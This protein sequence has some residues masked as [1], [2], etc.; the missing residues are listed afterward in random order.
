MKIKK[1]PLNFAAPSFAEDPPSMGSPDDIFSLGMPPVPGDFGKPASTTVPRSV[2]PHTPPLAPVRVSTSRQRGGTGIYL[3]A[4]VAS[5]LWLGGVGA[6]TLGYQRHAG[7]FEDEHFTLLILAL[8]AL[9]PVGLMWISAFALRQGARLTDEIARLQHM[10][11]QMLAPTALAVAETGSAVA[12]IRQEVETASET[13]TH[14]RLELLRVRDTLAE[15]SA[16]LLEMSTRS[17]GDAV[18]LVESLGRERSAFGDLSGQLDAR[19]GDIGEAITRH[20]RMVAEASDLAQVQIQE[21]EAALAARAADLAAAAGEATE[22]ARMAGDDLARQAARLEQAG[23]TVGEQVQLVEEGLGQ[24]RAGLVT[25]AHSMRTEHEDLAVQFESQRAQL[26]ETLRASEQGALQVS[27][28]AQRGAEALREM[29]SGAA[30]QLRDMGEQAQAERDLMGGAALQ[31]LGAFSEAAAFERRALEEETR[32]AL[33]ELAAAAESAHLAAET[34][35]AAARAKVD[36]LS[37]AAFAAGQ[38]ADAS[39]EKRL[40]EARGLIERSALL[41]DEAG[42]RS[43][44]KLE[45]G[46]GAA[47]AA[48]ETLQHD[49]EE[50]A[51]RASRLPGDVKVQ[52]QEIRAAVEMANETL[53][54]GAR[55]AADELEAIDNAFQERVKRNYEMLSEAVRLMGVL[56]GGAATRAGSAPS[57]SPRAPA[58]PSYTP[59]L[60]LRRQAEEMTVAPPQSTPPPSPPPEPAVEAPD[61]IGLRPRLKLTV[62]DAEPAAAH[63]APAPVAPTTVTD[64]DW[65]WNEL[66]SALDEHDA[67]DTGMER[68]LIAEIEGLG[69]DAAALI[70]RRRLAD[71]AQ[72]HDQGDAVGAREQVHRLA[73]AAVRK[74]ARRVLSDKL[75]RAQADRFIE[76]YAGL[77]RGAARRG[78]DGLTT[79]NLLGSDAGRAYLLLDAAVGDLD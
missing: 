76:R 15:E 79:A 21:A 11:D 14:A 59:P 57:T 29:I 72:A 48:L 51:D 30:E 8:L 34:A 60:P 67:D 10:T 78:A 12:L 40:R 39:F 31:S 62:P 75:M 41:V 74:L 33:D 77:I 28:V 20:A 35:S 5:L 22:A 19:V 54:A 18:A 17:Y 38:T 45:Q 70:P 9:A 65:T 2:A 43:T 25:L 37:E 44:Q 49:L 66:V 3:L 27:E 23:V 16:R 58:V 56:G 36:Q 73:P 68:T 71:I 32:R 63:P 46:V 26:V 55:I 4:A 53:L 24:Q 1:R 52:G 7:P 61:D 69:I 6:F 13:A 64:P 42:A 47:Q 50:I